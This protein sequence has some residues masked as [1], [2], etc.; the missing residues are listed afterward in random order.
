M[1]FEK[2]AN[3][4]EVEDIAELVGAA[5]GIYLEFKKP[6]EFIRNGAFSRDLAAQELAETISAFLNSDG[7]V[8]LIGVQ[9]DSRGISSIPL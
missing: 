5:E 2:R 6:S 8:I 3:L 1:Y 9:T 4:W 7:G